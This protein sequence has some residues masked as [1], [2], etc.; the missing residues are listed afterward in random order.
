[1]KGDALERAPTIIAKKELA[2]VDAEHAHGT[3]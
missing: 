2:F 1:V 3:T